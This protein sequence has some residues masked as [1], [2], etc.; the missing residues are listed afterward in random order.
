M[1][2]SRID[3]LRLLGIPV[4]NVKLGPAPSWNELV[5]SPSYENWPHWRYSV[6]KVQ[7]NFRNGDEYLTATTHHSPH[8][9][10]VTNF[11]AKCQQVRWRA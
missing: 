8:S 7:V 10:T 6:L 3:Q 2:A 1:T 11:N 9:D 4:I 5:S